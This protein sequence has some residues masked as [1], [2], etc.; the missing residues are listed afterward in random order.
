MK[1]TFVGLTLVLALLGSSLSARADV[2]RIRVDAIPAA[3]AERLTATP[4][5]LAA[6]L[7][8]PSSE[9]ANPNHQRS[10]EPGGPE[11]T[12]TSSWT[13]VGNPQ[14]FLT[15]QSI[16]CES[17]PFSQSVFSASEFESKELTKGGVD[18]SSRI[19]VGQQRRFLYG[20]NN[21]EAQIRVGTRVLTLDLRGVNVK[22]AKEV[23]TLARRWVKRSLTAEPSAR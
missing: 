5:D 10:A 16:S 6:T 21:L 17:I 14:R 15:S 8:L 22:S 3:E 2:P 12:V 19:N 18:W 9:W 23:E 4:D 7:H 20:S 13:G 1:L 11:V